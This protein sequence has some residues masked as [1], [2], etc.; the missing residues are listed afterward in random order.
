MN[1]KHYTITSS[2]PLGDKDPKYGQTWLCSVEEMGQK[3]MFNTLS[4]NTVNMGDRI[5]FETEE[6]AKFKTGKNEGKEYRRLRKVKIQEGSVSQ[7]ETAT[8][9]A[10]VAKL[11]EAVFGDNNEK[12]EE[13]QEMDE[14]I[15]F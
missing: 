14:E 12:E 2:F 11:E 13:E 15:P 4:D 5:T 10:R 6:L 1:D 9:E 3:V 7:T 8:M